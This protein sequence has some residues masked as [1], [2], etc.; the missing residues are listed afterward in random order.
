V[1][2]DDRRC[3]RRAGDVADEQWAAL[4]QFDLVAVGECRCGR[5]LQAEGEIVAA[6]M[7]STRRTLTV[8]VAPDGAW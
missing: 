8:K 6:Q 5:R 2:E 7:P 4:D 1:E 3:P